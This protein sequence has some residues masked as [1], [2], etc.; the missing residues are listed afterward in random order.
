MRGFERKMA[1]GSVRMAL[2][3]IGMLCALTATAQ[4]D[5]RTYVDWG[6]SGYDFPAR[7]AQWQRGEKWCDD[8]NFFIPR[9][10]PHD[11]FI[12]RASQVNTALDDATDKNL[13]MWM[14]IGSPGINAL[15]SGVYDS[16]IFP[17]WAYVSHLGDWSAPMGRLPG[18]LADVAR[19]NG[20]RVST[21]ATIPYG[22]ITDE[23]LDALT[24]FGATDPQH[25]AQ[26][27]LAYGQDGIGYNSE[28]QSRAK[29]VR[30]L[31]NL[32]AATAEAMRAGG[33]PH[34]EFIWYNSTNLDGVM[35]FDTALGE[36]NK[37]LWGTGDNPHSALF[38][39]YN[40]NVEWLLD[41]SM[42]KAAEYGR[43]PL[44]LYCGINLQGQE[45]AINPE[46]WPML[47]RYPMS[48]GLWGAHA[49][50]M[51]YES[52]DERGDTPDERQR[53]YLD[54]LTRWFSGSRRNPADT[55]ALDNN[56]DYY[57][58]GGDFCGMASLMSARSALC[59]DLGDE[60]F[61]THFNLGNGKYFNYSG[62][63]SHDREWY[64][65]SAQ[66][67]MPTWMWWW[68]GEGMEAE[69]TWDDAWLGGS[70]VRIHGTTPEAQLRL[71]KTKFGLQAGD[72]VTVRTK[73]I[74]GEGTVSL[75]LSLT[76]SETTPVAAEGWGV[77]DGSSVAGEWQERVLVV[78]EDIPYAAG[79]EV[80]V[81]GLK[82]ADAADLD[83]RL[84]EVSIVRTGSGAADVDI[85]VV[86]RT[87]LLYSDAEGVDMKIIYDM[88]HPE[89]DRTC[90]NA[91]VN[92]A[93]FKVHA[94]QEGEEPVLMS[95]TTPWAALAYGAPRCGVGATRFR[96]GVSAV[97]LDR[98]HESDV[99]WGEWHEVAASG[100]DDPGSVEGVA[101]EG[102]EIALYDLHGRQVAS[103]T[104]RLAP[105]VY[106]QTR[107]V[108]GRVVER[109][110]ILIR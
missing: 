63:R 107:T 54:R 108:S 38:L 23:W 80:A 18:A 82:V 93:F 20:V 62:E 55:P 88:P 43:T 42:A 84:G 104:S 33:N 73:R 51:W 105:G 99:A 39:N 40:W 74:G 61:V 106:V 16:D 27:L 60:P 78:G 65:I 46:I 58:S 71:F 22:F 34:P 5:A 45:P 13:I 32:H 8:D 91:D 59:W 97:S 15:P 57:L 98:R 25:L 94:Q 81:I 92:T 36:H 100:P 67:Y 68:T 6:A 77:L 4:R 56:I 10:T 95:V 44:D 101:M 3:G 47:A 83:L 7:L 96:I 75:M 50:N 53:T 9:A 17:M 90:L 28:F 72:R 48:I 86:E 2:A 21:A 52:R 37:D 29:T 110:K 1:K 31:A 103:D 12:N 19:R 69:F 66:D 85:P 30:N 102:G 49:E 89:M 70:C 35:T 79:D 87:E 109:R 11:R 26:Y 76:G 24:T 14:P 41:E 64:D